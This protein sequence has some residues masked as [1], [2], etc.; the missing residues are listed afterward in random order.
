MTKASKATAVR[1]VLEAVGVL[2]LAILIVVKFEDRISAVNWRLV[3]LVCIAAAALFGLYRWQMRDDNDYDVI[4]MLMKDGKADLSALLIV[5]FAVL[6]VWVV[7]QQAL[8]KALSTELLLGILG[9]FVGGKAVDGFSDAMRKRPP[10]P[11]PVD[12]SVNLLAGAT[13]QPS[14]SPPPATS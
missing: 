14:G 8:A 3:S 11:P 13:V 7:V 10:P 4:D 12:Q 9:I 2:L 6:S 5:V 1:L